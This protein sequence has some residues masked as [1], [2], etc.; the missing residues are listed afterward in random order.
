MADAVNPTIGPPP[1]QN[2]LSAANYKDVQHALAALAQGVKHCEWAEAAGIDC[3]D[4]TPEFEYAKEQYEK[5]RGVYFP[6]K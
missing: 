1:G 2:P 3:S 4:L 5:L 6:S